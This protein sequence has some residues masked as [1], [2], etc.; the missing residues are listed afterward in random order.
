M[1]QGGDPKG[2][3]SGGP[4][5]TDPGRAARPN[6]YPVGSVAWAKGE[7]E[8]AGHGGLAVLHRDQPGAHTG[9]G[10][11]ALNQQPYQYGIIGTVDDGLDVAQKIAALAPPASGDGTPTKKVTINKVTITESPSSTAGER[12]AQL[13]RR[14]TSSAA[15]LRRRARRR[16]SA[17]R[18]RR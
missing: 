16:S 14:Q 5:Y 2:D 15:D 9:Q 17:A 11:D 10:L 3:G 13:V 12:A 7:H 6:G 4:G 18:R 8:P 1:I